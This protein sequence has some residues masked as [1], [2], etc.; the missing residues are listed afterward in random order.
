M[1]RFL[2]LLFCAGLFAGQ[3]TWKPT[4]EEQAAI[5]RISAQSMR[6]NL[7]FLASDLLEG[8]GTPSR[9]LDI[10]AEYI[11]AQFRR[12]G[13]E[14]AGPKGSYFQIAEYVQVQPA[15]EGFRLTWKSGAAAAEFTAADGRVAATAGLDL[16][17]AQVVRLP[18]DDVTGKVVLADAQAYRRAE[19]G[20][21]KARRPAL[22][23]LV[24]RRARPGFP[25]SQLIAADA[26]AETPTIT[27]YGD[28]AYAVLE[29]KEAATASLHLP[30]PERKPVQLK[31]V[32]AILRGSDAALRDQFVV[33][34]A[35]Y[36]HLGM[37]PESAKG[38]RIFNGANDNGSGT[39]SVM[40]IASALATSTVHPK[41]SILFL[42]F[43]GE[44]NGLIGSTYYVQHPLEPLAKTVV[45]INL[46]QMGRTDEQDGREVGAFS[47]TGPGYSNAPQWMEEAAKVE[48][49]R[50]YKKAHADDFFSRSDNLAFAQAGVVDHTAVVAFEYPD[51]HAVG[52]EWEKVDYENMAKVDRAVAAGIVRL[53]DEAEAPK[54]NQAPA[55]QQYREAQQRN[56]DKQ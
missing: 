43:F 53:A 48:G 18:V 29:S 23:V 55:L 51:Y 24:N 44:E 20:K 56:R 14:P 36:D 50:V 4:P 9:G 19:L 46:E 47:F 38:D 54:W 30:A 45:N 42:T 12:A 31:N 17:D 49:I 52:D 6:G 39:V 27:L 32:A 10:A 33:L 1:R 15:R 26:K 8:R 7:S 37:L 35:H 5:D 28:K 21:L 3:M 25:E 40:E 22:I 16:K 13:L 11:A 2:G 41:R 34:S